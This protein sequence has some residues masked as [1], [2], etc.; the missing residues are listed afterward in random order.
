MSSTG[1]V[2]VNKKTVTKSGLFITTSNEETNPVR[3]KVLTG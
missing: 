1:I 2:R 3:E